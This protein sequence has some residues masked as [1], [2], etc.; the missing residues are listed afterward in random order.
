MAQPLR[1]GQA[2]RAGGV[3]S[4]F[5]TPEPVHHVI[6]SM[7]SRSE[8]EQLDPAV[9]VFTLFTGTRDGAIASTKLKHLDFVAKMRLLGRPRRKESSG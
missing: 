5:P 2:H 6:K 3:E 4:D 1:Q 8:S 9:G 7:P